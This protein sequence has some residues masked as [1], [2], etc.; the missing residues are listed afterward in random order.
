LCLTL[1]LALPLTSIAD[2]DERAKIGAWGVD[3][4]GHD[5]TVNPGDDFFRFANGRWLSAT[6]IPADRS[7]WGTVDELRAK[8]ELEVQAIAQRAAS[9]VAGSDEQKIGDFYKAFLD[10]ERIDGLGLRPLMPELKRIAALKTHE[11]VAVLIETRGVTV[12]GPIR[13]GISVDEKNPDRY[14][15][16]VE[17]AGLSLPDREYYLRDDPQFKEIRAKFQAHVEKMLSLAG[18]HDAR[19]EAVRILELETEIAR[20]HWERTRRRERE[21]MYN[22]MSVEALK[23]TAPTYPWAAAFKAGGLPADLK[24]VVV[25]E[26]TAI[27]KLAQLFQSTPVASW[28][29]YLTYQLLHHAAAV[30][31]KAFDEEDFDFYGRALNGQPRQRDRWKR[32]VEALNTALGDA[33]GKRYVQRNFSPEAKAA[34]DVL[35]ENLRQTYNQHISA[36][37][38]MTPETQ[39]VALEKLAAFRIKIGYPVRWR[40]Y[41]RLTIRAH[42]ALGNLN[43]AEM[44]DWNRQVARLAKPTDRDEW[45]SI[46]GGKAIYPQTVNAFAN[47]D[48]NEVVFPAAVLQPPL[49]DSKADAAVNFGGIGTTI[50]HEIGHGFDDQGAKSDAK[51]VLHTWWL[52]HD[53]EAFQKRTDALAE[54]YSQFE[55]LPGLHLN[56]RLTLGENIGDVGGV[57]IAYDAYL[58]SLGGTPP[59]VVD[60]YSGGQRFFLAYAQVYRWLYREPALRNQVMTDPHAP[61]EYRVNGVVRNIDAWYEAFGI[62]PGDKLYLTRQ[63]RVQI[64]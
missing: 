20:L 49:F 56:G 40:D 9:A 16:R 6:T 36:L 62:K 43:R 30:L 35:V 25:N 51:G 4:S 39:K 44:F 52:Q 41:S 34:M 46:I 33:V 63:Q 32:A 11:Q 58:K 27:P 8:S 38:W 61:A 23:K 15:V 42:D 24:E 60:G 5:T 59:P 47:Y 14:I 12:D 7:R 17:Q 10:T 3:L 29:S 28:R 57:S 1:L 13:Y 2:E 22:L 19:R 54:Q 21:L 45:R 18:H 50:G 37:T 55:P 64:W 48:F 31:P 26:V 53:I